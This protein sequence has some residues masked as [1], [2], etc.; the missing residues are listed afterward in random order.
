MSTLPV[1]APQLAPGAVLVV[2]LQAAFISPS[3]ELYLGAV[4][5]QVVVP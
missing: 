2:P 5:H 3:G 4:R 1:Q